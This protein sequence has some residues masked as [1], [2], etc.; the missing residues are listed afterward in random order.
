MPMV[1]HQAARA[2]LLPLC[3]L[4]LY[5]LN[6]CASIP[7]DY[8]RP[9][10]SALYR[11]EGTSLGKKIQAQAVNH[12]GASGF[13]LLP[14]GID[15]FTARALMIDR[16]EKTLDLQYYIFHDD[17]MGK[18]V[19][20]RLMAAADRGVRVRLLLDDWHQ[21]PE[22]DWLLATMASHP[23]IEVRLFNPFGTHRRTFLPRVLRMVFGP[24]RLRGRMHNKAFIADNSVAI[25]GGRNIGAEY[26][27]ASEEFNFYDVDLMA[28]GPIARG[29]S[30][31]FD[32][33]WNCVLAMPVSALVSRRPT[34]DDLKS[35]RRDLET[36]RECLKKSTY[37]LKV[38]ASELLKRLDAG[39]VP[40]VWGQAEVL[41]DHP[42]KCIDPDDSRQT[43]KMTQKLKGILAAAQSELL[44]VTPYFV[45]GQAGMRLLREMRGRNLTIKIITNSFLSS[46]APLAQIG[47]MRYR[48]D[49]L[50]MGV[51]LYEIKPTLVQLQHDQD[52][53]Q[54]GGDFRRLCNSF[55]QGGGS[56]IQRGASRIQIGGSSIQYGGSS[57]GALHAKTFVLDHQTVFVGSFNFDPRSMKLDTQNGIV[58][59]SPELADQAACLFAKG[60][61]PTRTYRVT[62]LGDDDLV[63]ITADNGREVRYYQ[64]PLSRFWPR[65]TLRGLSWLT[66]EL[67]L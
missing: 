36:Q 13:Y 43:A 15:A 10:S 53:R 11:P 59:H 62:L 3:L 19:Y 51:E 61:S 2:A 63:W 45:P 29:V 57:R 60:I 34:A 42:L 9:V 52:R 1:R 39:K 6:G 4:L 31:T 49:L 65:L 21:T 12:P 48:K 22:T 18:F 55:I 41:S 20:N 33:H 46:D 40:L 44:M 25:V 47:Y 24:Q 64:E 30:A 32:D 35:A 54:F 16:A 26:F 28:V 37:W 5:L 14:T 7:Y 38:Q 23:N 58:I 50:R 8:P 67:L 66:P 27:G 17:L 56:L